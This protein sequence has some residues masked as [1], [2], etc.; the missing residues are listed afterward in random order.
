[1]HLPHR[2]S[3]GA[4][5]SRPFQWFYA[6]RTVS[7]FGS[8]MTPVALS[9]A[10]LQAQNGQRLLGFVLAAEILPQLVFLLVGGSAADRMRRDRLL[11]LS[12]LGSGFAQAGVASIVLTGLNPAWL[13]PLAAANGVLGAFTSP[14][15]RGIVPELVAVSD[16]KQ[17]NALLRTAQSAARMVGP[18]VA[19]VLV[20]TIGGGWGIAADAGSFLVAAVC[21]AQVRMPSPVGGMETALLQDLRDGWSYFRSHRWIWSTTAAFTAMNFLQMG[22]WQVLGPILARRTFGS[23]GW[24]LTLS[25]KSVGL[26]AASLVLLRVRLRRPL[27]DSRYVASQPRVTGGTLRE[28]CGW[29]QT[30][31]PFGCLLPSDTYL[32]PWT[33]TYRPTESGD[34]AHRKPSAHA[35]AR[36]MAPAA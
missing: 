36:L 22:V 32:S 9:F 4:L 16:I 27:R 34:G 17:A 6:G 26:L 12:H 5:S 7:L 1:M 23:A 21:F 33:H 29:S 14:A 19:G 3:Q 18:T 30:V 35:N 8:A 10:V 13:F 20:A 11:V 25:M 31:L 15:L 24:G 28:R 2:F